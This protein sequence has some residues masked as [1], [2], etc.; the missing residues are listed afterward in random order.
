MKSENESR[1]VDEII[2]GVRS[3]IDYGEGVLLHLTGKRAKEVLEEIETALKRERI[4]TKTAYDVLNQ[5][6]NEERQFN[7]S[8]FKLYTDFL[9]VRGKKYYP[10]ESVCK[11]CAHHGYDGK[12]DHCTCGNIPRHTMLTI[13]VDCADHL[14]IIGSLKGGVPYF[15]PEKDQ[16]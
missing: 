10:T 5:N 8:K 3:E 1:T 13:G 11:S 4:A 9:W 16:S 6:F 15:Y 7:D 12:G 14:K 2:A